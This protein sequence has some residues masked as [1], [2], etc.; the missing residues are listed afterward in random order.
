MHH[1]ELNRTIFS[2]K[3]FRNAKIDYQY[4]I[5]EYARLRISRNK[6]DAHSFIQAHSE[7][8]ISH[9]NEFVL[10][11]I[12][13]RVFYLRTDAEMRKNESVTCDVKMNRRSGPE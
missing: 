12:R 10:F 2:T 8:D 13:L 5:G 7:Y 4:E 1:N 11:R 3:A 6:R 9:G